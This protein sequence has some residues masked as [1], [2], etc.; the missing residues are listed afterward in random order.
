MTATRATVTE[1]TA[2][3]ENERHRLYMDSLFSSKSDNL[4]T[5]TINC[6]R[7]VTPNRKGILKNFGHK[8]NL[9]RSDRE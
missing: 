4:H 5:K 2:R 7:N 1:L 8:I 6:C 3:I 9:K